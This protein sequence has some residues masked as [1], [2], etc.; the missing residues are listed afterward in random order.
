VVIALSSSPEKIVYCLK[1]GA[2]YGVNYKTSN[3]IDEVL[4]ITGGKGVDVSLNSVAGPTLETDPYAIKTLGRWVLYGGAAGYG[5]I[6]QFAAV[7]PKSQTVSFFS[8]YTVR[9]RE[10][11]R[12]ATDFM[13][14]WLHTEELHS[15]HKTFALD[16]I[17]EAHRCIDTQQSMGKIAIIM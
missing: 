2:D 6:D 15:V 5:K 1:N 12:Q 17:A 14:H 13:L 3:Y 11:Y 9:E 10:E 16:D 4:Q 7:T 8:V